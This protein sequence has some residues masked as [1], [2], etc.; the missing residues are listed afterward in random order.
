[1]KIRKLQLDGALEITPT[2]HVDG[3]GRFLEWYRGDLVEEALGR[4]LDLGQTSLTVSS[5]GSIRGV[6]F[7]DAP[8]GQVKYATCVQGA[9]LYV[10]VDLRV[11][12]PTFGRFEQARLDDVD[13]RALSITGPAVAFAVG[14]YA[15]S[16]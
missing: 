13:R 5:R 4:P 7:V 10:L 6:H 1:M 8:P 3:R 16:T 12:S 9:A 2:Q 14:T 11:G 15:Q